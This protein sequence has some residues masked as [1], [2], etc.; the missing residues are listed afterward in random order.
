MS[1]TWLFADEFT[2][3][4]QILYDLM[5]TKEFNS[6]ALR[7]QLDTGIFSTEDINLAAFRYIDDCHA[8][9][10]DS[11]QNH[12]FDNLVYGE[13]LPGIESS[14]LV[15]AIRILLEYGLNPNKIME[16]DDGGQT[17]IMEIMMFVHNGY[18]AADAAAE[19]LEHGGN[20][21]LII[22]DMSLI[23]ELNWEL[24]FFL[25]GDEEFRYFS[26][27][28]VHYWMVFIGYGAKLEDGGESVD[29]VDN[30]DI[31]NFRN[32]RQYYYGLIHSDRSN[33]GM[34]VCF[35]DKDTNWE[36]ARY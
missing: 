32:H 9:E 36:V 5:F 10:V 15:D 13:T 26:D 14:H 21:S 34:E 6:E 3:N 8:S 35:F 17:N 30:F 22:G 27:S 18:Q 7:E 2:D 29:P 4:A 28:V 31:S 23:R 1:F 24:L 25:G 16:Y 11:Y 20:P 12:L 33:D 19:M